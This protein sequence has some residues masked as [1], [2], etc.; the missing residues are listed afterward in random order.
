MIS[1]KRMTNMKTLLFAMA[2]F[3][4]APLADGHAAPKVDDLRH[5]SNP[6]Y[7]R[8]VI[9]CSHEVQYWSNTLPGDAKKGIDPRIYVDLAARDLAPGV[10]AAFDVHDGLLK[11]VR[12]GRPKPGRVRVVLDLVSLGTYKVF[13]L[14][15]PYRIVIDVANDKTPT[16]R[17]DK[18]EL[19]S[20]P[21]GQSDRIAGVLDRAPPEVPP[22]HLKLPDG[23]GRLR[24]IVVDAGHGGKDPGAVGPNGVL[25]KDVVL[26]LARELAR[27]LR[28][29][30]GCEVILTRDKDVFL[31]LEERT[32]IANRVGADLFISLHVNASPNRKVYG[33]ETYY[34]NL[35][36]NEQAVA[37]AARENG[38][39]LKEVS[40]LEAILFDLMANAKINESSRLA[41]EV[42]NA[43]IAELSR[44]YSSIKN[45]GVLQG[46]FYVLLG[47]TM[48]SVLVEV[49]FISNHREEKRLTSSGFR[50]KSARAIVAGVKSYAKALDMM[51]KR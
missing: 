41:A 5:W 46:P 48:P 47:A 44:H 13:A 14:K 27:Q 23:D 42:Q 37:V 2:A 3:L 20:L 19:R 43:L 36:K 25:E 7:T 45:R 21:P 22:L 40:D 17:A 51:A 35:S 18:P 10:P 49:G 16:I 8:V 9:D 26:D 24:R 28:S 31:P 6:S 33:T 15:D 34:L 29:E 32:A 50:D 38:T 30:L 39:T 11:K 4:L 12:T 1:E